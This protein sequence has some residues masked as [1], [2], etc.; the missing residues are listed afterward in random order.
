MRR[1][2]TDYLIDILTECNYL[3]KESENPEYESFINND[4]LTFTSLTT[5]N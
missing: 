5:I 3:L 2:I 1:K 4:H